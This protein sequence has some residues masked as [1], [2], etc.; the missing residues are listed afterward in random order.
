MLKRSHTHIYT[1][2]IR[3]PLSFQSTSHTRDNYTY[4]NTII[5]FVREIEGIS[6]G[7]VSSVWDVQ[8]NTCRRKYPN[9]KPMVN[10]PNAVFTFG[11]IL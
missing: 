9:G 2:L 8:S 4:I 6:E 10:I 11:N 3:Y 7:N 5:Y 1:F